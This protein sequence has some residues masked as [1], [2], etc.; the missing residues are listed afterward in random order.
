[1]RLVFKLAPVALAANTGMC[2]MGPVVAD[3]YESLMQESFYTTKRTGRYA[4][5]IA[6]AFAE[7]GEASQEGAQLL[8]ED[9]AVAQAGPAG[10]QPAGTPQRRGAAHSP[11][12][13]QAAVA[14]P[15]AAAREPA[16]RQL[17]QQNVTV[18]TLQ[19]TTAVNNST[20]APARDAFEDAAIA[21]SH[22]APLL[23]VTKESDTNIKAEAPEQ[24]LRAPVLA[25]TA[26][27]PQ[28]VAAQR[29]S[30]TRQ[31]RQKHGTAATL[32]AAEDAFEDAAVALLSPA[33]K[34][35][36]ASAKEIE[37]LVSLPPEA[38][39][40]HPSSLAVPAEKGAA[41]NRGS[42]PLVGSWPAR[43]S[44]SPPSTSAKVLVV[45]ICLA[46]VLRVFVNKAATP[47]RRHQNRLGLP[48][49]P[50]GGAREFPPSAPASAGRA[51]RCA[52]APTSGAGTQ[53]PSLDEGPYLCSEL[54]VP[55]GKECTL[56]VPRLPRG[57][58][59]ASGGHVVISDAS[60][61]PVL[62]A[63]YS[64]SIAVPTRAPRPRDLKRL[65][66]SSAS[67]ETAFA[68]CRDGEAQLGGTSAGLAIHHSSE[69]AFGVL[70]ADGCQVGDGCSV[71]TQRGSRIYFRRGLQVG[72][73]NVTDDSGQLLAVAEPAGTAHSVRV[74]QLVDAG[75]ITLGLLG[76]DL[77][78]HAGLGSMEDGHSSNKV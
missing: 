27:A 45:V 1:M 73:L 55:E 75:L 34:E 3:G 19:A 32:Q 29:P 16:A 71:I 41:E 62:R 70:C 43:I 77:L 57:G 9:V 58:P 25:A 48:P 50:A 23:P 59:G 38:A 74:G 7:A 39:A 67:G 60:G 8:E 6:P 17:H 4:G 49:A 11:V 31:S 12:A 42:L 63:S 40:G 46:C 36:N 44:S 5:R 51:T 69:T 47:W 65:V 35:T 14:Q 24:R 15:A 28:P 76:I 20:E 61:M 2:A 64:L 13:T 33:V 72:S 22:A 37:H 52:A 78:E 26:K 21:R 53:G 18:A 30:A 68:F 66:L 54:I 56:V 10:Q